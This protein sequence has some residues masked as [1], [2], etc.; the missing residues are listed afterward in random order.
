MGN[1]ILFG[2]AGFVYLL[3]GGAAFY[4]GAYIFVAYITALVALLIAYYK[5]KMPAYIFILLLTGAYI[6]MS[7][8][9]DV[10]PEHRFERVLEKMHA[11]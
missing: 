4:Y 10:H 7:V 5:T 3:Y 6:L 1:K 9:T 2:L 8:A 11:E